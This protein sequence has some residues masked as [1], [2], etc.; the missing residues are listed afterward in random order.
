GLRRRDADLQVFFSHKSLRA[1]GYWQPALA[2]EI[3]QASAFVLLVGEKG[4]GP[5]EVL[6]Y[7]EA[8]DKRVKSPD[9]P[10]VLMLLEGQP[11]PGLP[12]LRQLHWI[13]AAD[14][15]SEQAVARLA[16]ATAGGSARPGELWRYTSPYRGLAAM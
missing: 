9:F 8:L 16:E 2:E 3:A 7:Y 4:L 11:A 13:I 14:P 6:E 15:A 12:F 10:V 5:W 1:G